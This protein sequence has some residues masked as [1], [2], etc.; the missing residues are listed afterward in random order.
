MRVFVA[1]TTG[2]IGRALV[3]L[4]TSVGHEVI[5]QPPCHEREATATT[6]AWSPLPRSAGPPASP[7][8][9]TALSDRSQVIRR[10]GRPP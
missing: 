4:L 10:L 8:Q 7:W 2:V 6:S 5:G 1:G 9:I 3:P